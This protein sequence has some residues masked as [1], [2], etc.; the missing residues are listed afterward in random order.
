MNTIW[1]TCV[2]DY[3][4]DTYSSNLQMQFLT[5][6]LSEYWVSSFLEA[7]QKS[8]IEFCICKKSYSS[9]V[10]LLRIFKYSF[11]TLQIK[12]RKK[13][14]QT[15]GETLFFLSTTNRIIFQEECGLLAFSKEKQSINQFFIKY[16]SN[17][18][19]LF[20][21]KRSKNVKSCKIINSF[22]LATLK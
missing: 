18:L 2:I 20:K 1:Q 6:F 11:A 3:T 7:T 22:F 16:L 12:V 13:L 19:E 15:F 21:L 5:S 14:L 4:N 8:L 17:A 9:F 10:L